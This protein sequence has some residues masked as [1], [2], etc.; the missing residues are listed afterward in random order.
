MRIRRSIS[1]GVLLAFS[2]GAARAQSL[3]PT[4]TPSVQAVAPV[5]TVAGEPL[6]LS[7]AVE[8]ALRANR[9][10]E[11][12]RLAVEPLRTRPAE[13]RTLRPPM[14]EAQAWQW[15]INS[16][17]PGHTGMFMLMASQELPGR[18]KRDAAAA[19]AESEVR[20]AESSTV[21]SERDVVQAVTTTYW[22]LLIA[23]RAIANHVTSVD[24]LHETADLAQ[25]K[26]AAGQVPQLD[27]IKPT[28][29]ATRLHQDLVMFERDAAQATARLNALLNR[30]LSTPVGALDVP[31][32]LVLATP[33]ADLQALASREQPEVHSA[34]LSVDRAQAELRVAASAS[35][36]DLTVGGG[37]MVQP[38]Q[39]DAWLARISVTWPK[40]P[41]ARKVLDTRAAQATAAV[42]AAE[43][44]VSAVE[45][46]VALALANTYAEVKTAEERASVVRT[47]LLPQSQQALD[48]ARAAYQSGRGD[49]REVIDSERL[50]LAAQLDYDRALLDWRRATASLERAV[51]R[52][53]PVSMLAPAQGGEILR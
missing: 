40:A 31:A 51:G 45:L 18:G 25:A 34:R 17:T 1:V 5:A 29:E 35:A 48:L 4:A 28:V 22:D 44:Q 33:L 19:L 9:G 2:T 42:N 12:T 36:P 46:Q 3:T 21:V 52:T 27:V 16:L 37:Y 43:A 10:L 23:R 47:A 41:W 24:L 13:A 49:V 26:Y 30:P 15:P 39:T 7:D 11:A 50:L 6:R 20:V 14:L 8:E 38:H 32:D 53:L